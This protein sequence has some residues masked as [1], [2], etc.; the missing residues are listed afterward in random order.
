MGN[1]QEAGDR[2][3]AALREAAERRVQARTAGPPGR[4]AEELLHELAVHQVELEMQNEELRIAQQE[5][6]L[7][8]DRYADL[9]DFAPVGYLTLSPRGEIRELNLTAARM[10][11]AERDRLLGRKMSLR[12]LTSERLVLRQH[13]ADCLADGK[14]EYTCELRVQP[15]SGQPVV[16]QLRSRCWHDHHDG[17]LCRTAMTDITRRK[18]AE[19]QLCELNDTLAQQVA[20]RTAELEHRTAQLQALARQLTQVEHRERRRLAKML[21]DHLQ[22]MLVAA[23][24]S[25][26]VAKRKNPSEE[27]R[28]SLEKIDN[29]LNESIN[30]SRTLTLELCPPVLYDVGLI[31]GLQ[32]VARHMEERQDFQVRLEIDQPVEPQAT[33]I[34]VL[35]FEA[36]RELLFNAVKHAGVAEA[37]VTV[38]RRGDGL[39][40]ATVTDRGEGFDP[41][42]LDADATERGFG[43][44]HIRQ[45]LDSLGGQFEIVSTPGQGTTATVIVPDLPAE[46]PE[47]VEE[48][49]PPSARGRRTAARQR[50]ADEPAKRTIRILLADD[51]EIVRHGLAGM[52]GE[53]PDIEVVAEAGDGLEA[54]DLARQTRPDVI[55]MDVTMPRLDGIEAT[56]RIKAELPDVTIIGLSMHSRTDLAD[57]MRT[58]GAYLCK[59]DCADELVRAI[60]AATDTAAGE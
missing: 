6:E 36:V 40:S 43:L 35:L 10:L 44:F 50:V 59:G 7:S 11:G 60:R 15:L 5:L 53:E 58:A 28:V 31:A 32:W 29:L 13:I 52:L 45:R 38:E 12:V 16:V 3:A 57:A 22:Q 2:S 42:K 27:M 25:A 20:E 21:H 34:K 54:I 30:V 19:D 56:R 4:S 9:Y 1:G 51:H 48:S 26:G 24:I 37:A 47:E 17:S 33:E 14:N 55:L 41:A 49:L 18:E 46:P 8:R 39:L 23:R